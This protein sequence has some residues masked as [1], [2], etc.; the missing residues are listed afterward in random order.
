MWPSRRS[1]MVRDTAVGLVDR[2]ARGSNDAIGMQPPNRIIR[3]HRNRHAGSVGRFDRR[4][5]GIAK[6]GLDLAAKRTRVRI[7]IL[8]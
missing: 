1:R 7:A 4:P 8:C 6:T 3:Q 5:G 2:Q